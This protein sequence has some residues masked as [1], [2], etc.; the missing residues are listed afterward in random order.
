[1]AGITIL[2]AGNIGFINVQTLITQLMSYFRV[3]TNPKAVFLTTESIEG[4]SIDDEDAKL[5]YEK[6]SMRLWRLHQNF[7]KNRLNQTQTKSNIL[8]LI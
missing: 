1:M 7:I 4:N 8:N 6:W 5:D 3:I 2:A